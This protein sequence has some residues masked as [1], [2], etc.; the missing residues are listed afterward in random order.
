M[1]LIYFVLGSN[2]ELFCVGQVCQKVGEISLLKQQLR[3]SQHEVTQ[4][5]GEM[6]ALRGQLKELN[7][8]LKEREEAMLSLKDSYSSKSRELE[9]CEGELK[10]TLTEVNTYLYTHM[11]T[12]RN[13]TLHPKFISTVQKAL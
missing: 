5:A 13:I 2:Y 1:T 4:R 3:D 6:V 12:Q 11:H 8:Q 9:R 7:T 10:K